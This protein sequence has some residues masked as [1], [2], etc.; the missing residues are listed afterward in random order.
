MIAAAIVVLLILM[1]FAYQRGGAERRPAV[2]ET[3]IAGLAAVLAIGQGL[4][5]FG[6]SRSEG[7]PHAMLEVGRFGMVGGALVL[8]WLWARLGHSQSGPG[9]RHSHPGGMASSARPAPA[10]ETN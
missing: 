2:A 10:E 1:A 7:A 9:S 8:M 4:A 6:A 3:I 5:E